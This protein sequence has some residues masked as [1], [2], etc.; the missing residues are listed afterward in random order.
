MLLE[1]EPR[2]GGA[3]R[4]IDVGGVPVDLGSHRL[5]PSTRADVLADLA[6]LL[7]PEL[8]RRA[9]NGRIRVQ[10]RWVAFPLRAA[11]LLRTLPVRFAAAAARDAATGW[12]RRPRADT[13]AEVLR[14]RLGPAVSE[15]VYFPF[16]QKIWGVPPDALS[17]EQARRRVRH[18]SS[19][20]VLRRAMAPGRAPSAGAV[21]DGAA[22]GRTFLYPRGGFGRIVEVLAEAAIADGADVR[23]GAAAERVVLTEDGA[24]VDAG[25][26]EL[27]GDLVLSTIP[28]PLLARLADP[29]PPPEAL[30]AAA[31]LRFRALL[32]AHLVVLGRP[33]TPYDAHY[34]PDP[35]VPVVRVSEP[36]QYRDRA[37]DPHDRTVLCA[38]LPC[39]T[40]D[41]LWQ[42]DDAALGALVLDALE[43]VELPRP[44][45]LDLAVTRL[46]RAY[47]VYERGFEAALEPVLAWAAAQ[48]RLLTFGRQGLFAYG[49]AHH[50]LEMAWEA[51]ASIDQV[52]GQV[53]ARRWAAAQATFEQ[54]VVED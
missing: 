24:A 14:T 5:H 47:P 19:L 2:L 28:V 30:A 51:V 50:A 44:D 16:A 21:D 10:G 49:N 20:A 8:Q 15:A 45:V 37:D 52:T 48:R 38:E 11:D 25:G 31:R 46:P 43:A 34:I 54:F 36:L 18:G 1:R 17:G 26:H 27:R 6:S 4:S 32:V 35:G 12:M 9:R 22:P 39:S 53:D 29:G 40:G 23:T 41:A 3:S 42:A 33:W 7:G 13:Y